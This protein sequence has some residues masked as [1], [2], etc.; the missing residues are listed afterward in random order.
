L[1]SVNAI[2][3]ITIILYLFSVFGYFIDFLQHNRKVNRIAFWLL[4][5]V[6]VLQTS[7]FILRMIEFNRLPL[8]TPF[9]GLFFYAWV[10]VTLSLIIN[11]FFRV[12]FLVFFTNVVGFCMMAFSLF[13]PSGDIPHELSQLLISELL[14]IHVSLVLLSYAGFTLA[15]VFSMLYVMQHQMLKRKLWGKR[16]LRL[17]N[18]T[19]LDK[20]AF[21]TTMFTFPI[22]LFGILLGLLWAFIK[23]GEIPWID[24][25]V[26]GSFIVIT[27]YAVYLYQRVVKLV[28]GYNMSLLN[29]AAFLLILINYFLSSA[30]S[31]FHLW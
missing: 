12:D 29:I 26:L 25:K 28:R 7:F 24:T 11:W 3:L 30:F 8:M 31:T 17:G 19:K 5:I 6:W 16:L 1:A 22:F 10:L 23:F 4:S 27:V 18:L 21:S 15:F 9:E 20:F 13:T 14:I 2:Y